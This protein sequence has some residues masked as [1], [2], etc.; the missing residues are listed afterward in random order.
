MLASG[1][2]AGA[3][4]A[5]WFD[6]TGSIHQRIARMDTKVGVDAGGPMLGDDRN[7]S[8]TGVRAPN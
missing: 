3:E 4:V 1:L 8:V 2:R 7:Y 5:G 6:T